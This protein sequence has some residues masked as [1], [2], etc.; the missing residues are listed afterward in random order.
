MALGHSDHL[1]QD[2]Q[3]I[4][5]GRVACQQAA[6]QGRLPLEESSPRPSQIAPRGREDVRSAHWWPLSCEGMC[7]AA[8]YEAGCQQ[9]Q[10][11][12]APEGVGPP[13]GAGR[14]MDTKARVVQE[15]LITMALVVS[16]KKLWRFGEYVSSGQRAEL[17]C[18]QAAAPQHAE[19]SAVNSSHTGQ[20]LAAPRP[21]LK[22]L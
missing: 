18:S 5:A 20:L 2:L 1:I 6:A 21:R 19:V 17:A 22:S 16:G 10:G 7:P 14:G 8:A 15:W 3:G 11:R 13:G 12:G 4:F 9:Q